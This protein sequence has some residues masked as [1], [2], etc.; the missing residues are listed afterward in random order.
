MKTCN[1]CSNHTANENMHIK[2]VCVIEMKV[3]WVGNGTLLMLYQNMS[4]LDTL[5]RLLFR[6]AL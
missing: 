3:I 1:R 6:A 2:A 4:H 5:L